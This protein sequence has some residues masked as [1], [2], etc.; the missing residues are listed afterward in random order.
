MVDDNLTSVKCSYRDLSLDLAASEFAYSEDRWKPA[1][2]SFDSGIAAARSADAY[3]QSPF[4]GE[5]PRCNQKSVKIYQL[6]R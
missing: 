4:F 2:F 6:G 3:F 1:W 5:L